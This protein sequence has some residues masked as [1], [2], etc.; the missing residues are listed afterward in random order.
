MRK[1]KREQRKSRHNRVR[2]KI[3]GT[4][5]VPRVSVF[6]S[7]RH[8][9]VQLIDDAAGKTLVSSVVKSGKKTAMKGTK[10][11]GASAIGEMLA[12]KAQDAGINKVVFDR[13]GF[14]YHGRVRALAEGLR[15]GGLSF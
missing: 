1:L 7:N 6:R 14:K 11:E 9:F 2:A 8:V 12:K 3:K 4:E 10:T 13:G 5:S 15:K